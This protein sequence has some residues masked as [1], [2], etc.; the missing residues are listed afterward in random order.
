[1]MAKDS[2]HQLQRRGERAV[3]NIAP[4]RRSGGIGRSCNP[5]V[6]LIRARSALVVAMALGCSVGCAS[7]T[8]VAD[9][10]SD[11][12]EPAPHIETSP[13]TEAVDSH[14]GPMADEDQRRAAQ[15]YKRVETRSRHFRDEPIRPSPRP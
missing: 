7:L 4:L 9:V 6:G 3:A 11:R 1:M 14:T 8:K 5:L 15:G 2:D 10:N 13:A 12:Q